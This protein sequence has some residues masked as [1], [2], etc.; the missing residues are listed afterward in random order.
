MKVDETRSEFRRRNRVRAGL[1]VRPG[2]TRGNAPRESSRS[3]ER[4]GT[5][6]ATGWGGRS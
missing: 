5:G 2:I 1:L 3:G 6:F 4:G